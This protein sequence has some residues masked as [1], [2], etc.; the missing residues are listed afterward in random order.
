MDAPNNRQ[1]FKKIKVDA[2]QDVRL[3]YKARGVLFYLLSNKDGWRG[4]IYNLNSYSKKDGVTAIRS[5]MKEL[6]NLGYV[7]LVKNAEGGVFQGSYYEI[8]YNDH[9]LK[10]SSKK[11]KYVKGEDH[12]AVLGKK[13]SKMLTKRATV[14]EKKFKTKL[15]A[16]DYKFDFQKPFND[17]SHLYVADFYIPLL[18]LIIELDGGYHTTLQQQEQDVLRDDWFIKN[19]YHIW[20]LSNSEADSILV[21]DIANMLAIYNTLLTEK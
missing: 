13:Y 14:S 6:S 16:L 3:S 21:E 12:L 8:C 19:G 10:S 11:V 20:R 1:C 9:P 17:K 18:G 4:Q 7:R 5:A 15:R 2:A